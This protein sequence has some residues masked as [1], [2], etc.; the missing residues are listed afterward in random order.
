MMNSSYRFVDV[1]AFKGKG[2]AHAARGWA[3]DAAS[4]LCE[5]HEAMQQ[6]K[7]ESKRVEGR[8]FAL[9][10]YRRS[11]AGETTVRWRWNTG[12]HCTW[13]AVE[14]HV[15]ALPSSMRQYYVDVQRRVCLLNAIE[16]VTR[17]ELH[18]AEALVQTLTEMSFA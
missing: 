8:L 3:K 11:R 18:R 13:Q 12:A 1:K 5:A 10:V 15:R 7:E 6:L 2:A 9:E 16:G 4:R 14:P 17:T